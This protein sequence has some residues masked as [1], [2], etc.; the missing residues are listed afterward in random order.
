GNSGVESKPLAAPDGEG[1]AGRLLFRSYGFGGI[2]AEG[3]RIL[4]AVNLARDLLVLAD[5]EE[6]ARQHLVV[7]ETQKA[8]NRAVFTLLAAPVIAFAILFAYTADLVREG[9]SLAYR[10]YRADAKTAELKPALDRRKSYEAIVAWYQE[11][12]QQV[13]SLR[14]QQPVGIGLLYQLD[15]NYPIT[16]DPSFYVSELKLS[17]RGDL[18]IKGLARNKDAI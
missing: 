1:R 18:E 16:V 10:E 15:S 11:Y 8:R 9:F 12:V 5:T 3:A 17:P 4:P 14:R 6:I 13:S 7:L 2:E